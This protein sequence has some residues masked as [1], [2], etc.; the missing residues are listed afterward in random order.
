MNT[1]ELLQDLTRFFQERGLHTDFDNNEQE[2]WTLE[3]WD[4]DGNTFQFT[5]Q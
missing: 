5:E 4:D 2:G 1:E 3:C